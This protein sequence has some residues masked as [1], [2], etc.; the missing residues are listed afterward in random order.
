[1]EADRKWLEHSIENG[2][3][4]EDKLKDMKGRMRT[5][6]MHL[7]RKTGGENR[8]TEEKQYF[9]SDFFFR[10]KDRKWKDNIKSRID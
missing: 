2:E 3:I 5:S 1:M 9:K 6:Y 7:L 10:I 4:K 8:E